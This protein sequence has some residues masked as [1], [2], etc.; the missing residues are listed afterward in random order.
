MTDMNI[1]PL[2]ST[3]SR[4]YALFEE[5][6]VTRQF[7][8]QTISRRRPCYKAAA[9]SAYA[10]DIAALISSAHPDFIIT[11]I[12]LSDGMSLT[13]FKRIG[14]RLPIV[15]YTSY[16]EELA[17]AEGLNVVFSALKPV[18]EQEIGRFLDVLDD[19]LPEIEET[20]KPEFSAVP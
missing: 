12:Y 4:R 15:I 11:S 19:S 13:E 10:A 7:L 8:K 14:C 6:C 17:A 5:E 1:E 2:T 16:E 18:T 9:E 20:E 3:P